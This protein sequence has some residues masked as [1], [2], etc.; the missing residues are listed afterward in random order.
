MVTQG[1]EE[2]EEEEEAEEAAVV[3]LQALQYRR[4][5]PTARTP[6]LTSHSML[7]S[8]RV[9]SLLLSLPRGTKRR[10]KLQARP[11]G[12]RSSPST[13]TKVTALPSAAA[14][15]T[16]VMATATTVTRAMD[17]NRTVAVVVAAVVVRQEGKEAESLTTPSPNST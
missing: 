16:A 13:T 8:P 5:E 11:R 9:K 2:E 17:V 14:V 1:E 12:C 15:L 7:P 10:R 3:L 4:R 6:V